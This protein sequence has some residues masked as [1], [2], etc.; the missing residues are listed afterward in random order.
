MLVVSGQNIGQHESAEARILGVLRRCE[1]GGHLACQL[2]LMLDGP[3]LAK[4]PVEAVLVI[5]CTQSSTRKV[6][7]FRHPMH[8]TNK[9]NY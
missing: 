2:H 4:V 6:S 3:V 8:T 5:G 9:S 1:R 7:V